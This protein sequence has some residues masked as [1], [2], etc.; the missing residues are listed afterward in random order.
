MRKKGQWSSQKFLAYI[1]SIRETQVKKKKHIVKCSKL[2]KENNRVD[3]RELGL[4]GF[5]NYHLFLR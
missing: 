1:S 5:S 3:S 2:H 4:V